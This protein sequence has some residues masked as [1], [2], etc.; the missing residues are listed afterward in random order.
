MRYVLGSAGARW[1][2]AAPRRAGAL[3]SAFVVAAST[4][5]HNGR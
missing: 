5:A 1:R 3:I 4:Y 2:R